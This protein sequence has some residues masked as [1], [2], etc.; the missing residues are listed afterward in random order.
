VTIRSGLRRLNRRQDGFLDIAL[1][2]DKIH[3]VGDVR[4]KRMAV[5]G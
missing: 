2:T 1:W 5:G 3:V 4:G